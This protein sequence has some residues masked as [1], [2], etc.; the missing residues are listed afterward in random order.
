MKVIVAGSRKI[1]NWTLVI[2]AMEES[3]FDIKEI[4]SGTA[5][6]VDRMG[7]AIARATDT[8][9]TRFPADWDRYGKAAG[10]I[11]NR[12]MAEYAD[13]AVVVWDGESPGSENMIEEMKRLGKPVYVKKV[14]LK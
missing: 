13:A 14:K 12:A 7:E 6:G 11:R 9:L 10:P 4:V 5:T 8:K 3:K 1:T 2:E